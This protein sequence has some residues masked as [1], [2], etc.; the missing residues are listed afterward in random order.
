M[1]TKVKN[2]NELFIKLRPDFPMIW[3]TLEVIQPNKIVEY[4]AGS[5]RILPLYIQTNAYEI[6]GLDIEISM[7]NSFIEYGNDTNR[8]TAYCQDV[9]E[10]APILKDADIVIMTSSVMKHIE[11]KLRERAWN[12]ISNSLGENT[13]I[14]IDHCTYIYD[15]NES[16]KW[17]N[18]Y[19]T[20]KFWWAEE[21]RSKLKNYIWKK[22]V[23]RKEDILYIKDLKTEEE[24]CFRTFVYDIDEMIEDIKKENLQYIQISDT[25]TLAYSKPYTKRFIAL[26]AHKNF[27][28]KRLSSIKE[29]ILKLL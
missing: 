4:G 24:M 11:P 5:G 13:I 7:V 19:D 2:Y 21:D 8:I 25:F 12:A 29:N 18:Y 15:Q 27:D 1:Y 14:F 17:Q 26:L 16:T 10:Y 3:A 28:T 23:N 6:V 20:L 22:N 9:C